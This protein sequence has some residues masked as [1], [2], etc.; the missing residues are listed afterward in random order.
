MTLPPHST[1]LMQPLDVVCF[2]PLKHYH[3]RAIDNAL[4]RGIFDYNRLDFIAAIQKIRAETYKSSTIQSAFKKT[5]IVPFKPDQILAPLRLK[6]AAECP[7]ELLL[8]PEPEPATSDTWP[9]PKKPVDFVKYQMKL[10][11]TDEFKESSPS[12]QRRIKRLLL[13]STVNA[14]QKEDAN[15]A[16]ASIRKTADQRTKYQLES[17]RQVAKGGVLY[18]S[19]ARERIANR[20]K[21]EVT[22][23]R[24]SSFTKAKGRRAGQAYRRKLAFIAKLDDPEQQL[25]RLERA[26]S[27]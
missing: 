16:L 15:T 12:F 8:S 23:A 22:K 1:H 19:E 17:R 7:Q 5:G 9:S 24:I 20:R 14:M 3:R 13:R 4:R 27:L 6:Q 25:S 10:Q 21:E 26:R 11:Q 18:A 2:Q